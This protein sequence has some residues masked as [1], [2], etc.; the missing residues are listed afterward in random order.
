MK[1]NHINLPVSDVAAARDFF[2]TYFDM[3]TTLEIGKNFLAMLTDEAG[4]VLNLSHFD[5]TQSADVDYHKDFHIG[6][7]LETN[8]EV[9]RLF[10]R[11]NADGIASEP[12]KQL[13]GR[14]AFYVQAPGGVIVEVA[15]LH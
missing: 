2:T 6:F 5:K 15:R 1:L 10:T 11:M 9:D 12:P 13:Q 3:V 8:T 7:F 4:M 14:Y